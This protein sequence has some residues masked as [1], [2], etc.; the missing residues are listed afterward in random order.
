MIIDKRLYKSLRAEASAEVEIVPIEA[1][2]PYCEEMTLVV[3]TRRDVDVRQ[4]VKALS[5]RIEDMEDHLDGLFLTIDQTLDLDALGISITVNNLSPRS[6]ELDAAVVQWRKILRVNLEA[7]L[8]S[9]C[10]NLVFVTDIGAAS[11]KADILTSGDG[12]TQRI[13]AAEELITSFLETLSF[14]DGT[15]FF[16]SIVFSETLVVFTAPEKASG[17]YSDIV[18]VESRN[19]VKDH[20]EW[21]GSLKEEFETSPSDPSSGL[22]KGLQISRR[23]FERNRKPTVI[24]FMSGG[25]YSKGTNPVATV[26]KEFKDMKDILLVC[27]GL[28]IKS[29][30]ALLQAIADIVE[31]TVVSIKDLDDIPEAKDKVM[32]QIGMDV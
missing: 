11:R 26:R 17:E 32:S 7:N 2:I 10:F 30:D 28:G 8:G 4:V 29:E 15:F 14:C 9:N 20:N 6:E 31:G 22:S 21:I 24:L 12:A 16:S 1:D 3:S 18:R 19:I 23:L 27:V 13:D 5:D 25:S